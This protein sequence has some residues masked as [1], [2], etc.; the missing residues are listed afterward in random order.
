MKKIVIIGGIGNGSVIASTIEDCRKAGQDIECVGYLNE[1]ENESIGPYEVLGS[2]KND[3]WQNL[4]NDYQ[5]IFALSTVK[6]A[7]MRHQ[8][9]KQMNIPRERYATIIHPAAIV[10]DQSDLGQG[11]VVMPLAL[12]SPGVKVG[13]HSQ[14]YAQAFIGHDSNVG[15]MVFLAANSHT[16]GR[17][18]V[19]DGAHIGIMSTSLERVKIGS[20]SIVGAGAV[21]LKDVDPFNVV[22]G[23]PARVIK[24]IR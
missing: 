13:D 6:K 18:E 5:F 9:L 17:V 10:S 22:V 20:Y 2:V 11:V 23:N 16:G 7:H 8:L 1:E 4:P 19:E 15:E 24:T 21:V 14:I 3:D 12:I